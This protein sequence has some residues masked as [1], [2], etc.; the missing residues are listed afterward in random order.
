MHI[1]NI[2]TNSMGIAG[3]RHFF[4]VAATVQVLKLD[5]MHVNTLCNMGLV[6]QVCCG[7]CG[8]L[9]GWLVGGGGSIIELCK[10]L[11]KA[12]R[13]ATR[14]SRQRLSLKSIRTA[15]STVIR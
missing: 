2:P 5:P 10:A 13:S 7:V 3:S 4:L 1:A 8:W 9:V 11:M 12:S 6:R 14:V 15:E